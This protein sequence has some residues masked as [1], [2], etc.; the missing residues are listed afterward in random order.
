MHEIVVPDAYGAIS[1]PA[2]LTIRRLLPEPVERVWSFLTESKLRKQWLA[3]GEMDLTEG[4][5]FEYVWRNDELSD[6][7]TK[8]PE[9]FAEEMRM[10][11]RITEIDPPNRLSI[12]WAD[13]GGVTFDLKPQGGKVLLTITHRA[14]TD[15]PTMLMVGAGWHM[16]L[17]ILAARLDGREP[18]P[19]WEG[20]VR[21]RDDY[22]RRLPA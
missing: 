2:T 1:E 10:T 12:T 8:R 21:L 14:L 22:D 13:S 3:E 17:D 19:F 5:E 18:K 16:H 7:P 6:A 9:G 20:W 4:A 15:R 11:S